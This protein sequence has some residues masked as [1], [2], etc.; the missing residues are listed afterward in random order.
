MKASNSSLRCDRHE[1][2]ERR[3][4][5]KNAPRSADKPDSTA[6]HG[7]AGH[8]LTW[9]PE[10]VEQL[11]SLID[12]GL[13]CSQ[14]AGEIGITRNA[15]IGKV[16]RLGLSRPKDRPAPRV[17]E[18]DG[19]ARKRAAWRPRIILPP[20]MLLAFPR[21]PLPRLEDIAI[22]DGRGCS[23][24]ELGPAQCRW[25]INEPGAAN[26]CFCGNK[27]VESLPYCVG[28]AR[29]AYKSPARIRIAVPRV[30]SPLP[31]AP[32][33]SAIPPQ[34]TGSAESGAAAALR[35]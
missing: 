14:I 18:R 13:S 29:I 20:R 2:A 3:K 21:E 11:K 28:H 12:A 32:G 27:P 33:A 24:M 31:P 34:A 6:R 16:S 30:P 17:G 35:A 23:L 7:G 25:P 26:F 4:E 22:L 10:R 1:G 19:S 5:S 8:S 15:V 9:P